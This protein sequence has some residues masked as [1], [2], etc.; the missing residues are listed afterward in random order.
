MEDVLAGPLT[1]ERRKCNIHLPAIFCA[2]D[3]IIQGSEKTWMPQIT[4][5]ETDLAHVIL[6]HLHQDKAK[7]MPEKRTNS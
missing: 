3:P 2:P 6:S 1:P 5:P 7:A 4:D